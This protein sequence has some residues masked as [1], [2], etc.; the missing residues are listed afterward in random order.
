MHEN[1]SKI[2]YEQCTIICLPQVVRHSGA[3][4]EAC[5][6]S[7]NMHSV[8]AHPLLF[9]HTVIYAYVS[10]N[11]PILLETHPYSTPRLYHT[12]FFHKGK[13]YNKHDCRLI[14]TNIMR[15]HSHSHEVTRNNVFLI[16]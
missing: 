13:H 15:R 3:S 6:S 4:T 16:F 11:L 9:H 7:K 5:L 14:N 1:S 10:F 8:S 12:L 2:V